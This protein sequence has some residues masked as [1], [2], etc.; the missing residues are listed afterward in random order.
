M[1]TAIVDELIAAA[2]PERSP[3]GETLGSSAVVQ[4]P[5]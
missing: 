4:S 1:P 5:S 2:W 3:I